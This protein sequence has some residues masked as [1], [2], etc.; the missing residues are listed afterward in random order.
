MCKRK[1]ESF[2]P[3]E[4]TSIK[5]KSYIDVDLHELY[6]KAINELGLQQT[7][8]D[9]IIAVYIALYAFLTPAVLEAKEMP[10]SIQGA[11][12]LAA[13]VI[14][15]FLALV[16]I[17]YRIYKEAYWLCCQSISVFFG[18]RKMELKKDLIQSV[19]YKVLEKKETNI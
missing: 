8:R 6:E 4:I 5:K 10:T 12:F 2:T 3:I 13:A 9:Q 19:F 18:I 1:K 16:I 14:G 7:K 17:R 11:L 15:F